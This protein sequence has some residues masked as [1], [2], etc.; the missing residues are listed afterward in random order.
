LGTIELDSERRDL[1]SQVSEITDALADYTVILSNTS[2]KDAKVAI[3]KTDKL[4]T[5]VDEAENVFGYE[6][7]YVNNDEFTEGRD[8]V[9]FLSK[10]YTIEKDD[11]AEV[12]DAPVYTLQY[13]KY[14]EFKV[15]RGQFPK[16]EVPVNDTNETL[17]TETL[18]PGETE[19]PLETP[20]PIIAGTG[21]SLL[22]LVK[23][24]QDAYNEF[25]E[26]AEIPGVLRGFASGRYIVHVDD[27]TVGIVLEGGFITEVRDGGIEDPNTE[28]WTSWDY[29][30][31][32]YASDGALGLVVAG[33]ANG[34][35]EKK[36]YGVGGKLKGRAGLAGLRLSEVFSPTKITLTEEEASGDIK[37]LTKSVVVG[38]YAMNPA[39]SDLRR[40]HIEMKSKEG[41]D[42]GDK[43]IEVKEYAGYKEGKA[44]KGL[45]KW[46]SIEGET[47]LGTF[48]E[49]S[50]PSLGGSGPI[51]PS[52][53]PM[54]SATLFIKYSEKELEEKGLSEENLYI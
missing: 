25:M 34:E 49:I 51:A 39:T 22:E 28:I 36:D 13:N 8:R 42:L 7:V 29:L 24:E 45:N 19:G 32:I 10:L 3:V 52:S 12:V 1:T 37:E 27:D 16:K 9:K 50:A 54:E 17:P 11:E 38:T 5:L 41:E 35:I 4:T 31:K 40:T 23:A 30:E 14:G 6:K 43:E 2:S 48:V 18:A 33:L 44:P 15:K 20:P 21:G 46:E 53:S 26:T 47:S